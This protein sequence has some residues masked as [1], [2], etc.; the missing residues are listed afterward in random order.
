MTATLA[1]PARPGGTILRVAAVRWTVAEL[2]PFGCIA[3]GLLIIRA[4]PPVVVVGG[5]LATFGNYAAC[6]F[7]LYKVL[8]AATGWVLATF[9]LIIANV[10]VG[11]VTISGTAGTDPTPQHP[12]GV[13]TIATTSWWIA[14]ACLAVALAVTVAFAAANGERWIR[15]NRHNL[16]RNKFEA[17][18][19]SRGALAWLW[20]P[21]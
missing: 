2:I 20:L 4:W 8:G 14:G 6:V 10:A 5:L 11:S 7:Y 3:A 17:Y 21:R 19:R 1:R 15:H 9:P 16:P 18:V 12:L 13:K